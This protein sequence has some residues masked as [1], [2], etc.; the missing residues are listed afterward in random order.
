[1]IRAP[2]HGTS[3]RWNSRPIERSVYFRDALWQMLLR[4]RDTNRLDCARAGEDMAIS[5]ARAGLCARIAQAPAQQNYRSSPATLAREI[6]SGSELSS[7][8]MAEQQLTAPFLSFRAKSR[9]LWRND[10]ARMSNDELM[11]N[12][13]LRG[14]Y[15]SRCTFSRDRSDRI[16]VLVGRSRRCVG[17]HRDDDAL[18][19]R[20]GRHP[21]DG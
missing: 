19:H 7:D 4:P 16:P 20:A 2:S 5:R 3:G 11:T 6:Q 17:V 1:M 8:G 9:N 12:D 15:A 18:R 13:E 21:S 10:E 14:Y